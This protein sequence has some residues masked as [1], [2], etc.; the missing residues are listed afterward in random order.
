[1]KG[2]NPKHRADQYQ[3]IRTEFFKSNDDKKDECMDL[4]KKR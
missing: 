1:M 3:E 2:F 4:I